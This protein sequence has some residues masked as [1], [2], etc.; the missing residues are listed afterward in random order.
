MS[1]MTRGEKQNDKEDGGWKREVSGD[2]LATWNAT[3]TGP[4]Q[5]RSALERCLGK[6]LILLTLISFLY[7]GLLLNLI[8]LVLT[9]TIRLSNNRS[10]RRWHK[11]LHGQI[12]YAV[13]SQPV[14]LLYVWPR[15][16]LNI[17]LDDMRLMEEVKGNIFGVIIANHTFELDWMTCFIMADQLGNM[18]NYK[19]FSK[20]ELKWLPVI[21]W[22]FWMADLIYVKRDWKRDR[23][24]IAEKLDQLLDYDQILLGIFAEGTRWTR[25]K[26]EDAFKFARSRGLAPYKHHLF[27]RPRGFNYTMRHYLRAA[28]SRDPADLNTGPVRL[29]NLEIV[30]PDRPKFSSFLEGGLLRADVYCEEV[31]LNDELCREALESRDEDDCPKLTRL[32]Q[33][34]FRR[35]DELIDEY[36]RNGQRFPIRSAERGGKY[37]LKWPLKPLVYWLLG[38]SLTYGSIASLAYRHVQTGS[39]AN[40]TAIVLVLV[41]SGVLMLRRIQ[42]ESLPTRLKKG[43]RQEKRPAEL[44]CESN[45]HVVAKTTNELAA[46]N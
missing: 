37:P 11:K 40:W 9:L 33:D 27:P 19:C 17:V 26:H 25:E 1:N 31:A 15:W 42:R 43:P 23:L 14:F 20:D 28:A 4:G 5:R 46:A 24:R 45:G 21:G 39:L 38:M 30:M 13:F 7:V 34:I 29:F 22:T 6:V 32:L 35:K 16:Q 44:V 12:V 10:W 41:A 36:T 3:Q 2:E 18:G 8:Q